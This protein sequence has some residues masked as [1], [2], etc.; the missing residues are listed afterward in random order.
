[1]RTLL[2][3]NYTLGG[4]PSDQFPGNNPLL[5]PKFK[6]LLLDISLLNF[7]LSYFP[8][9]KYRQVGTFWS[10]QGPRVDFW[11]FGWKADN[12]ANLQLCLTE[13]ETKAIHLAAELTLSDSERPELRV[14]V[15]SPCSW[16]PV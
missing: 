6:L 10:S 7:L 15:T 11:P 9:S 8:E 4:T 3:A 1:M 2:G 5:A 16:V 14:L 12:K 13:S